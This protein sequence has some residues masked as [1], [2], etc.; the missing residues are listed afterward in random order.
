VQYVINFL[1][2]IIVWLYEFENSCLRYFNTAKSISFVIIIFFAL[3]IPILLYF[4]YIFITLMFDVY[5]NQTKYERKNTK[6]LL[7]KYYPIYKCND[8]DNKF[9]FPNV[10]NIGYLSH[11]Y[12]LIVNTFL[13][14]FLPIPKIKNYELDELCP[15]FKGSKQFNKI[16]FVQCMMKKDESYKK[17]I[18]NRYMDP[19]KF[20]AF[21]RQKNN[22]K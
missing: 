17:S 8:T 19:D 10:F 14:F 6:N 3:N 16:E 9:R 5:N 1:I 12:Y 13:H 21:C 11:F 18:E 4:L 7:D 20:I 2:L 15:I 22:Q